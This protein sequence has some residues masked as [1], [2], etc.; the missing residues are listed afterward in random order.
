MSSDKR[1]MILGLD[2]NS[3]D[4]MTDTIDNI[5]TL[6]HST[7]P[8]LEGKKE[9][10]VLLVGTLCVFLAFLILSI[11]SEQITAFSSILSSLLFIIISYTNIIVGRLY[12][13]SIK[14]TSQI[15]EV[16]A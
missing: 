7:V 12:E 14:H 6:S 5:L 9:F 11:L 13:Q 10:I 8:F 2:L 4:D 3:V 1:P 15:L 16:E